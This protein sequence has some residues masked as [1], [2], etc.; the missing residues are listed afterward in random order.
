M[1]L[2][3]ETFMPGFHKANYNHDNDQNKAIS[4]KDDCSTL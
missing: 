4:V 2:K 3:I 1:Y